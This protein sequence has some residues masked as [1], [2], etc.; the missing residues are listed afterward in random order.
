MVS[1]FLRFAILGGAFLAVHPASAH[2]TTVRSA[3]DFNRDKAL[4]ISQSAVGRLVRDAVLRDRQGKSIPLAS[5]R[6]RP[7]VVSLIYTSC[8]HT[9]PMITERLADAVEAAREALGKESFSVITIGFDTVV[10][11]PARMRYFADRHGIDIPAWKFLSADAATI[12][13]L[14]RDLGFIFFRSPKGYDHL[15]QTTVIDEEGRV[16]LQV[17]GEQ[18]DPPLVV[19]PLKQLVFGKSANLTS[20][21]GL[22]SQVRLFCT[23]YNPASRRYKFDYSLFVSA[24]VGIACLGAVAVFLL[25]SWRREGRQ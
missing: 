25:R 24:F 22:I 13:R 5:F 20:L 7:L 10:D 15:S 23:V 4:E 9:C 6:G 17:Y 16:Y 11:T 21:S 18:F 14:T 8:M 3:R 19:E 1:R 2:G 12:D